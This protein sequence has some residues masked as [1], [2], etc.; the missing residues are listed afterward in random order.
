VTVQRR[1]GVEVS[2]V[3]FEGEGHGFS[4]REEAAWAYS[5]AGEFLIMHLAA[6]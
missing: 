6:R 5:D 2:Y 3:V 4:R 1:R